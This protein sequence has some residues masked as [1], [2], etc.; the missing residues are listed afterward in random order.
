M[1]QASSHLSKVC[2]YSH[3]K[4]F[5]LMQTQNETQAS[6]ACDKNGSMASSSCF[7]T[8]ASVRS[9][10]MKHGSGVAGSMRSLM[11]GGSPSRNPD[12]AMTTSVSALGTAQ[13]GGGRVNV[14]GT[15][16]SVSLATCA[17]TLGPPLQPDTVR[18]SIYYTKSAGSADSGDDKCHEDSKDDGNDN[19]EHIKPSL[20]NKIDISGTST[21][22][23]FPLGGSHRAEPYVNMAENVG[24][25]NTKKLQ[26]GEV[27][28]K[29]RP[30]GAAPY[31]EG[32]L[33]LSGGFKNNAERASESPTQMGSSTSAESNRSPLLPMKCDL[34]VKDVTGRLYLKDS[35]QLPC[36]HVGEREICKDKARSPCGGAT[37]YSE[38]D[39]NGGS[40]L[41]GNHP[42]NDCLDSFADEVSNQDLNGWDCSNGRSTLRICSHCGTTKTPLWRSGPQGPKSLCNACGIRFKK[43]RRCPSS[44]EGVDWQG[45]PPATP[46]S[47]KFLSRSLKRKHDSASA[48]F[49]LSSYF[50]EDDMEMAPEVQA[51]RISKRRRWPA[52]TFTR[53]SLGPQGDDAAGSSGE[54]CLTWSMHS[55]S[56]V[57][58]SPRKITSQDKKDMVESARLQK[59]SSHTQVFAKEEEEAAVLLMALSCGLVNA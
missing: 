17:E 18:R 30:P 12:R 40:D 53:E 8:S 13:G 36:K 46:N 56:S 34:S 21:R 15:A 58:P 35:E 7:F 20:P 24:L 38:S 27:M 59:H 31:S 19:D 52:L 26:T 10:E 54:S 11:T 55:P 1:L 39:I 41:P 45:S 32:D 37:T 3:I 14:A 9:S 28:G 47:S 25:H 50:Q 42:N 33:E 57:S 49:S 29:L 51:Y 16:K 23:S 2:G 44:G 48:A 6:A 43:S 5:W 4:K 22:P